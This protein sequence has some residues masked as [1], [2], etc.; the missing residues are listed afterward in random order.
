MSSASV[1]AA[2]EVMCL[3]LHGRR[4]SLSS[5]LRRRLDIKPLIALTKYLMGVGELGIVI[6]MVNRVRY[7]VF[8]QLL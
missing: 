3:S 7:S 4:T 1:M 8:K 6:L 5:P 2:R